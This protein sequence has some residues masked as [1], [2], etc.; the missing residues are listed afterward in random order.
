M[1]RG[2]AISDRGYRAVLFALSALLALLTCASAAQAD[3]LVTFPSASG[4]G[5]RGYLTT[6]PGRG[7]FPAVVLLHSCLGLPA[8]RQAIGAEVA[9]WGYVALFVD[10]FGPRGL[11][12]TCAV[13]FPDGPPDA[14]GALAYS[15]RPLRRR[16]V[17]DRRGRLLAGRRHRARDRRGAGRPRRRRPRIQGRRGVLSPLRQSVGRAACGSRPSS[18]SARSIR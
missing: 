11:K 17:A 18:W 14:Y 13:D 9:H 16:S 8:N 12:E 10:D 3:E 15:R 5:I 6:P 4:V 2:A 1:D 7:P